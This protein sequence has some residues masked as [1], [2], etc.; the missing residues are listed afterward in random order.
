MENKYP[1]A[2]VHP[3][4]KIG[5][6]VV[7]E[8]FSVVAKDVVVGDG[9]W[10]GSHAI[11]MDGARIGKN[12][13]IFPGAV[14]AGA[15]QDL[16]FKGEASI[17]E[18][19]DN[20]VVREYATINRGTAASGK[21]RT[22]IGSNCMI[23]SYVHVAHDCNVG[24]NVVLVSYVGLAGEV[25]V[26]DYAIIGGGSMAHQFVR[27]GAHAMLAGGS[28]MTKDIPPYI[29]AGHTP[30]SF[31]GVNRIGLRRR[32][33]TDEQVNEIHDLYRIVY[34]N[35][36]NI[37]QACEELSKLPASAVRDVVLG[38]ITSSKRGVI[39]STKQ[40]TSEIEFEV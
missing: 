15:P 23:M 16:K 27:V 14:I 6:N 17:A 3:E 40:T 4:A 21:L 39:K 22:A 12:C 31:F 26:G 9:T 36:L 19:G 1:Y 10:I 29:L 24:N 34:Q 37:T 11:L 30:L 18:I 7:I 32:G 5:E 35:D 38:F 2:K 25:E 20:T 28:L 8:P 33:F 13:K